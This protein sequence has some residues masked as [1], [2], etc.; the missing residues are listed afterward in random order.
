MRAGRPSQEKVFPAAPEATLSQQQ[1]ED[2]VKAAVSRIAT[3]KVRQECTSE[4]PRSEQMK[5]ETIGVA[6]E[7]LPSNSSAQQPGIIAMQADQLRTVREKMMTSGQEFDS[8][9]G[10]A[11]KHVNSF[12]ENYTAA[13]TTDNGVA[14][15]LENPIVP[16]SQLGGINPEGKHVHPVAVTTYTPVTEGFESIGRSQVGITTAKR[17]QRERQLSEEKIEPQARIKAN[18]TRIST[19]AQGDRGDEMIDELLKELE[20]LDKPHELSEDD[21]A[22]IDALLRKLELEIAFPVGYERIE[23]IAKIEGNELRANPDVSA[24]SINEDNGA[25][26]SEATMEAEGR[27]GSKRSHLTG[28]FERPNNLIPVEVTQQRPT[29]CHRR[30]LWVSHRKHGRWKHE[31]QQM[32]LRGLCWP[33]HRKHGRWK[34]DEMVMPPLPM[35]PRPEGTRRWSSRRKRSRWKSVNRCSV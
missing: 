23:L 22:M 24:E 26:S 2:F 9:L 5:V 27:C 25:S 20:E 35:Q 29:L 8:A 17:S 11:P 3:R 13:V 14:A 15:S 31:R 19:F 21:E 34:P 33:T 6:R 7:V 12:G 30:R 1:A 4:I 28:R 18:E 16:W 10:G 32:G